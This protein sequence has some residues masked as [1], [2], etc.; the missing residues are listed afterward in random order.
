MSRVQRRIS[1]QEQKS[2]N[3]IHTIQNQ[4]QN[5]PIKMSVLPADE[6]NDR[7]VIQTQMMAPSHKKN[8]ASG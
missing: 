3:I 5:L 2:I 8:Y 7:D 1:E 6:K 4:E